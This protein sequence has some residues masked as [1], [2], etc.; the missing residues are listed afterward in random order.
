MTSQ[1]NR[2]VWR[3][4]STD[5]EVKGGELESEDERGP[6]SDN[7]QYETESRAEGRGVN[8][9]DA[10]KA[11]P[12]LLLRRRIGVYVGQRHDGEGNFEL[13][14]FLVSCTGCI[15]DEAIVDRV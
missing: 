11:C 3:G 14:M 10:Y 8:A 15:I 9:D 7:L 5:S 6:K 12:P 4:H 2:T 13:D 1:W